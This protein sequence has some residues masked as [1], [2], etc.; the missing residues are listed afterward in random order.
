MVYY[1]LI[2]NRAVGLQKTVAAAGMKNDLKSQGGP[3]IKL[4][5]TV[6]RPFSNRERT[7]SQQHADDGRTACVLYSDRF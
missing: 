1:V 5:T 2:E 7:D 4:S 3:R 6:Y